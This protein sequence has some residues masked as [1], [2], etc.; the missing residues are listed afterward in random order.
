MQAGRARN[1]GAAIP[2]PIG[3]R[4]RS[5]PAYRRQIGGTA[6]KASSKPVP[7]RGRARVGY[8]ALFLV[9]T[10]F[11]G[12]AAVAPDESILEHAGL[13][14]ICLVF[15]D[16]FRRVAVKGELEDDDDGGL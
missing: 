4:A 14:F 13:G 1:G 11:W 7:V 8:S 12:L 2:P 9:L 3:L 15:A 16:Q 10:A 6:D 5:C